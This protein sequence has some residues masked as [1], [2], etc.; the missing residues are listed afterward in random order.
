[1]EGAV[2]GAGVLKRENGGSQRISSSP[3]NA[4]AAG[5]AGKELL[6][7]LLKDKAASGNQAPPPCR[8]LSNDS[9]RSEEEE[10]PTRPGSHN[11]S[12]V[13]IHSF[14]SV[15]PQEDAFVV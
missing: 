13:R 11:N 5:D 2:C 12:V 4:G 9:L 15:V 1:V 10:G 8:Q 7:H 6:R 3:L 14:L